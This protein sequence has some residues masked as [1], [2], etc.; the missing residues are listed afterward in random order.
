[1]SRLADY[2]PQQLGIQ[3]PTPII[4][5][6]SVTTDGTSDTIEVT[7]GIYV[8]GEGINPPENSMEAIS[9]L[10]VYAA[11]MFGNVESREIMGKQRYLDLSY[12]LTEIVENG[13]YS[14][15]S[16]DGETTI[17][18]NYVQANISDFE[19]SETVDYLDSINTYIYKYINT[20]SILLRGH[21]ILLKTFLIQHMYRQKMV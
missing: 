11:L 21:I 8:H 3:L 4:E 14:I 18:K 16:D 19:F 1:M 10:Y 9:D 7:L 2:S 12:K 17:T 5:G 6:I 15:P 20:I 13:S